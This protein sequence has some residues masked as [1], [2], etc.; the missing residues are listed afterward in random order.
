MKNILLIGNGYI[1]K[2]LFKSLSQND[3]NVKIISKNDIDYSDINNFKRFLMVS[4]PF[5]YVINCSGFTGIPNID[6]AEV[7]KADCWKYKIGRAH[8]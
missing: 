1:G 2:Y 3:L 4:E 8:V 5:D 7:E 6:Q